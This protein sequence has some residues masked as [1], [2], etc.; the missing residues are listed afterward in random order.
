[1]AM[2]PS[3]GVLP[4]KHHPGHCRKRKPFQAWRSRLYRGSYFVS[5]S[6]VK[7][8]HWH[9]KE[10]YTHTVQAHQAIYITTDKQLKI[11]IIS[12]Y[13]LFQNAVGTIS[14]LFPQHPEATFS[15]TSLSVEY[16]RRRNSGRSKTI[17]G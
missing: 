9:V 12:L 2:N 1:M 17:P 6:L 4:P 15:T 5:D 8:I 7:H 13:Y 3:G 14:A 10:E 11:I 16:I